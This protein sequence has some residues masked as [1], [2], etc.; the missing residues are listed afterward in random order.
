MR[1][2][3]SFLEANSGDMTHAKG[4]NPMARVSCRGFK[5]CFL[6]AEMGLLLDVTCYFRYICEDGRVERPVGDS[7][8]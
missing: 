3:K 4:S 7:L 5:L 6:P 8:V 2:S 1:I